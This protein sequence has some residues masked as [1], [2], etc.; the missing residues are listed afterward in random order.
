MINEWRGLWPYLKIILIWKLFWIRRCAGRQRILENGWSN[1]LLNK[2]GSLPSLF[3]ILFLVFTWCWWHSASQNRKH[4]PFATSCSWLWL[5]CMHACNNL[6]SFV[7]LF[8]L[9]S[10]QLMK[11][12][13]SSYKGRQEVHSTVPFKN[14][15]PVTKFAQGFFLLVNR[16]QYCKCKIESIAW[17]GVH[18]FIHVLSRLKRKHN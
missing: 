1:Q 14:K 13:Y 15:D 18:W 7:F 11:V 12:M 5:S 8:L 9:K 17:W 4:Q 10:I 3:I 16:R 6:Q 2:N